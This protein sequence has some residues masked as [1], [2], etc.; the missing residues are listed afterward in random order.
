MTFSDITFLTD[1]L[2]SDDVDRQIAA[3]TVST[4]LKT[5]H[6]VWACAHGDFGPFRSTFVRSHTDVGRDACL[7]VST[8]IMAK[9][10]Y[11]RGQ[12]AASV[13]EY[14][15]LCRIFLVMQCLHLK[16]FLVF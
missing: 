6:K 15:D 5:V 16:A 11:G 10:F 12:P 13:L 3:P 9:V 8:L 2:K 14:L 7:S 1:K 4:L